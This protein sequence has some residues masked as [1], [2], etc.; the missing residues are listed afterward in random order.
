MGLN[1]GNRSPLVF[2]NLRNFPQTS[3]I[4]ATIYDTNSRTKKIVIKSDSTLNQI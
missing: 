1:Q 2:H 3:T 4:A